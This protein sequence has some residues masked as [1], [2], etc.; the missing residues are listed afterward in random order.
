MEY[1]IIYQ[2][3]KPHGIRNANGY[4]LFFPKI[5]KWSGQEKRYRDEIEEQMKLADKLCEFLNNT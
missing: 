1:M 4:V 2:N 3:N 5:S